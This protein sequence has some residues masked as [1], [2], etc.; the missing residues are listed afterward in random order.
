M[1]L[2]MLHG[3]KTMDPSSQGRVDDRGWHE[4]RVTALGHS[5]LVTRSMYGNDNNNNK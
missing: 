1:A 4:G 2:G 5:M 3:H